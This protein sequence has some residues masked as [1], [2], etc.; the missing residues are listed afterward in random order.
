MAKEWKRITICGLQD[1]Q[2]TPADNAAD[3]VVE[4]CNRI[5]LKGDEWKVIHSRT[6]TTLDRVEVQFAVFTD[7]HIGSEITLQIPDKVPA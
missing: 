7:K 6:N 5:E 3:I 4:L 1:G 2:Q